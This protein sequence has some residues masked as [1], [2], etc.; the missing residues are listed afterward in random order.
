MGNSLPSEGNTLPLAAASAPSAP[1]AGPKAPAGSGITL[2][3]LASFRETY[4]AILVFV[5]LYVFT[6]KGVE[7]LF[8]RSIRK[9]VAV[10]TRVDPAAGPGADQI[11]QRVD[12]VVHDSAWV[13]VGGVRATAIV[14]GADG[15]PIY[16]GGRRIPTP[17]PGD[18]I[19]E[20]APMPP[21]T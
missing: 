6:V 1:S 18:P 4:V 20:A 11:Q 12:A 3:R 10:A 14:L 7:Q 21:T 16:A 2:D 13:R 19:A 17:M 15:Q 5:L 9:D 8:G